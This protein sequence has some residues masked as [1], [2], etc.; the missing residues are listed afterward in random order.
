MNNHLSAEQLE[1]YRRQALAPL[2][3][4]DVDDHLATCEACRTQLLQAEAAGGG[5]PETAVREA[6]QAAEAEPFHLPEEQLAAYVDGQLAGAD[7]EIADSHLELCGQCAAEVRELR[8][9]KVMMSTYPAQQH[10]PGRPVSWMQ[11]LRSS[12]RVPALWLSLPAVGAAAASAAALYFAGLRP[13]RVQVAQERHQVAQLQ[14]ANDTMR[15]ATGDLQQQVASVPDLRSQVARLQAEN[16]ALR[17]SHGTGGGVIMGP[18]RPPQVATGGPGAREPL[19]AGVQAAI[20]RGRIEPPGLLAPTGGTHALMTIPAAGGPFA[21][22]APVATAVLAERPPFS[23]NAKEGAT[24]YNVVITDAQGHEIARGA[25]IP[26]TD[27]R[28]P[29]PLRRGQVYGWQVAALKDGQEIE[30]APQPPVAAKFVVL[31]AARAASLDSERRRLAPRLNYVDYQ[32]ATGVLAAQAGLLD[33]AETALQAV[34][35][36]DPDSAPAQKLLAGVQAMRS[37]Q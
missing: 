6:V 29:Q 7:R 30:R 26:G 20:Q 27:W 23:W 11:R 14:Q 28:P 22:R 19:P 32:L 17:Q 21:P 13:L 31:D 35:E 15:R 9:F 10:E 2:E 36:V 16:Q 12:W 33:T 4:L 8:A 37:R 3:L 34:L 18:P 5:A 25:G 1:R 24:G